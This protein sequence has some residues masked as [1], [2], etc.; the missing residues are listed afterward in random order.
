MEQA[1]AKGE[2]LAFRVMSEYRSGSPAWLLAKGVSSIAVGGGRFPDYN[3][4]I[5]LDYHEK[6]IKALGA[7]Y[8]RS[9]DIDHVDIGSIGCWGEWNMA[10]GLRSMSSSRR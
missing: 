8:G 10:G 4:P 5:F 9:P 1:K 7:R 3:N 6:L 2:R